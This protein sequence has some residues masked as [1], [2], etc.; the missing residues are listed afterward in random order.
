MRR[1]TIA[2]GI[3]AILASS[4]GEGEL[5]TQLAATLEDRVA[6]IR[7]FAESGRPGL[8]RTELR[9][10]V[11]LV[12]SRLDAGRID[13]GRATAILAAAEAVDEQLSLLPRT[14]PT[15][16][17]SPSPVDEGDSR[18]WRRGETREGQ[19]ER[20][21]EEGER[22]RGPRERRLTRS[23]RL[24]PAVGGIDPFARTADDRTSVT[25][26]LG[27]LAPSPASRS[28]N[29]SPTAVNTSVTA[30]THPSGP[31]GTLQW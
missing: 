5:P 21:G 30:F 4:C 24:R 15:E 6:Q 31:V 20:E 26:K 23:Y 22:R 7:T 11:E 14:A 2:L 25:R 18:R 1:A 16:S 13:D 17:P 8:A 12:V 29:G 28:G 27:R 19:G 10:L 3:I 9:K